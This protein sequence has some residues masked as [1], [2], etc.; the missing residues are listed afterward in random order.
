[1]LRFPPVPLA[2][3]VKYGGTHLAA[4]IAGREV[5]LVIVGLVPGGKGSFE[6]EAP[7]RRE[8]VTLTVLMGESR[9]GWRFC[10]V[11]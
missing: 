3:P 11:L 2:C 9:H 7:I 4:A 5:G 10:N 8:I 1:M 6:S